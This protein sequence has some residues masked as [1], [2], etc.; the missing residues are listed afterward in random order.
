M[1]PQ[2]GYATGYRQGNLAIIP[3][4]WD[5]WE[6]GIHCGEGDPIEG[7][8][9]TGVGQYTPAP[10]YKAT[11]PAAAATEWHGTLLF[12]YRQA[13][14]PRIEVRRAD[15]G[16]IGFGYEIITDEFRDVLFVS[17]SF[18]QKRYRIGEVESDCPVCHQRFV[19]GR[20]TNGYTCDGS[21][22]SIDGTDIFRKPGS[23]RAREYTYGQDVKI[24]ETK[25]RMKHR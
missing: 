12:P 21:F 14:T 22:L 20:P 6:H 5:G 24:K 4:A 1:I 23:L 9:P 3:L 7:W 16:D 25:A 2:G 13:H 11:K 8:L 17:N 15:V 19:D 18:S 10:M